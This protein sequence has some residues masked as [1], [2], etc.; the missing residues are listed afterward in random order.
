VTAA[1]PRR[2]LS[3]VACLIFGGAGYGLLE[4][5]WRGYTHFSMVITGGVCFYLLSRIARLK[6]NWVWIALLGGTIVT[7]AELLAGN[8]VNLWLGLGVWDYSGNFCNFRGQICV[9]FSVL[10]CGVSALVTGAYRWRG[11]RFSPLPSP[12]A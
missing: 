9:G 2:G 10:W 12:R 11:A 8:I 5:L 3:A 4:I 6:W 1:A 7:A